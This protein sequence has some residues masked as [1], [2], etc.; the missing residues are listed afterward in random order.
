MSFEKEYF[1]ERSKT[2]SFKNMETMEKA[3]FPRVLECVDLKKDEKILDIG[4]AFGYFL[5]L[6]D[7]FG[8]YTCG[9]D[10]SKYAIER[11]RLQTKASLYVHDI[12]NGLSMFSSGTYDLVVL[13]DIIEH[14]NNP[15]YV[16][17][18]VYR[19]LKMNGNVIITTPNLNAVDRS[20]KRLLRK[21]KGW[22]GFADKT[23]RHLY[24]SKSLK[25][26]VTQTGFKIKHVETPFHPL[27]KTVQKIAN[28]TGLGGQ[29]WL[30]A[31]KEKV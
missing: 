6:C 7:R 20:V 26:L 31:T 5:K 17:E 14:L 4:C 29:I 25:R 28:K 22:Y 1:K 23:H 16:M 10:I 27:P 24:T 30:L 2:R 15:T 21:G 12:E 19:V 8:C 11:A 9:V 3:Y 13:F 18:E